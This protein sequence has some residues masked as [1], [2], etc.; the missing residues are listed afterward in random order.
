M[1]QKSFSSHYREIPCFVLKLF[2]KNINLHYVT[3]HN[4]FNAIEHPQRI[5]NSVQILNFPSIVAA[6]I[7]HIFPTQTSYC[8]NIAI[9]FQGV[10]SFFYTEVS[11]S[12][13][14]GTTSYSV[15]EER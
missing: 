5:Q 11:C 4:Y 9:R 12:N 1:I 3:N 14:K 10:F 2:A 15:T 13:Q 6:F 7:L 8:L